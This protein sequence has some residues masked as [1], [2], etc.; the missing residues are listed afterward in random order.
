MGFLGSN[1]RKLRGFLDA[2]DGLYEV[3]VA[4]VLPR[5]VRS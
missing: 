4:T 5:I 1:A 2:I 3:D